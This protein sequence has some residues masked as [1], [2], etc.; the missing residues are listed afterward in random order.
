MKM[1]RDAIAAPSA[2]RTK[3]CSE[4]HFREVNRYGKNRPTDAKT[5]MDTNR[6]GRS[7]GLRII[8]RNAAKRAVVSTMSWILLFLRMLPKAAITRKRMEPI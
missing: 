4:D 2:S 7:A 3:I 8:K 5:G 1:S 6:N